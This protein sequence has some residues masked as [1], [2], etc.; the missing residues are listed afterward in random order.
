MGRH[1]PLVRPYLPALA[2]LKQ[3]M[4]RQDLDPVSRLALC[5]TAGG[6]HADSD[7]SDEAAACAAECLELARMTRDLAAEVGL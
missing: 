7:Q 3:T 1:L 4:A 6:L 5:E 2:V